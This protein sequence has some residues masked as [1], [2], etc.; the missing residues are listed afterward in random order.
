MSCRCCRPMAASAGFDNVAD[1]QGSS[2]ALLPVSS[3]AARKISAVAVGDERISVGS[4]TYTARQDLSQDVHLSE[5]ARNGWRTAPAACCPSVGRRCN[6]GC[7]SIGRT[8]ARS[9][10]WRTPRRS[11]SPVDR[12]AHP[13]GIHRWRQGSNRPFKGYN[14]TTSDTI[15]ATRLRVRRFVDKGN[16]KLGRVHRSASPHSRRIL[17]AVFLAS[18]IHLTQRARPTCRQLRS[19]AV[20][21]ARRHGAQPARL[22]VHPPMQQ[23][24]RGVRGA[25]SRRLRAC[26]SAGPVSDCRNHRPD[27]VGR[28]GR[29]NGSFK[30][31][32]QFGLR[33]ILASPSF[34]F[35]P[36]SEPASVAPG[37]TYRV[38][39]PRARRACLS[40]WSTLPDE[41]CCGLARCRLSQPAALA[42]SAACADAGVRLRQQLRGTVAPSS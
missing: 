37:A 24:K 8:S 21:R 33:R 3:P 27:V 31:G 28:A 20:Q 7:V 15:E 13:V 30:T 5:C 36:E 35:R 22:R 14:P 6:S 41:D 32:V 1:A 17:S 18:R 40:L 26:A 12:G 29:S 25:F 11:S 34:V 38:T 42:V 2:P 23:A 10:G 16:G 4:D 19:R 9:Q 39:D